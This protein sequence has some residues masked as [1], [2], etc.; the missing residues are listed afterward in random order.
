[1]PPAE[2]NARAEPR[3]PK[4]FARY[5][6]DRGFGCDMIASEMVPAASLKIFEPLT[7]FEEPERAYWEGYVAGGTVPPT[8]TV[9]LSRERGL[10][11]PTATLV[12]SSEHADVIERDGVVLVCP[13]RAKLRLLASVLA[14]HRSI[15]AEVAGAFMPDGEEDRATEGIERI[16]SDHPGWRNHVLESTWEVPLHWFVPFHDDE[17]RFSHRRGSRASLQY[18]TAVADARERTGRALEV[19]KETLPNPGV[20]APLAGITRWLQDFAGEGRVV[21]DYAGVGGMLPTEELRTD[22]TAREIWASIRAL[23]EGDGDR[24]AAHYMVAA[25]RWAGIRRKETLN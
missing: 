6:G 18:E 22:H 5:G 14:F 1:V 20:I 17:R 8:D 12:A 13:H 2:S 3:G 23:S 15:P 7:A 4:N 24:A 16:R 21:L 11:G 9:L 19:V 10:S 25:E